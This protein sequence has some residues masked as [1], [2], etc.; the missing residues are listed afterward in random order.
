[1]KKL[2]PY[3]LIWAFLACL[4]G[5]KDDETESVN[6]IETD[7]PYT[8]IG[9]QLCGSYSGDGIIVKGLGVNDYRCNDINLKLGEI[10]I[11][12]VPTF[13]ITL[14]TGSASSSEDNK[15]LNPIF[16]YFRITQGEPF[17]LGKATI[18]E[19]T[20]DDG[21][22]CYKIS[23]LKLAEVGNDVYYLI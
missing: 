17:R 6:R 1:M 11:D 23:Y 3:L 2:Y 12:K 7:G 16:E 14:S 21:S 8:E 19:D 4:T 5:C 15:H 9:K 10:K 20:F 22:R 18:T 13:E